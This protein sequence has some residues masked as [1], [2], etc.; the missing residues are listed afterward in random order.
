M[1]VAFGM[2]RSHEKQTSLTVRYDSRDRAKV[3][4]VSLKKSGMTLRVESEDATGL[5]N[6]HDAV[7]HVPEPR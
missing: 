3:T 1:V 6:R 7:Y 2:L 4:N 5:G